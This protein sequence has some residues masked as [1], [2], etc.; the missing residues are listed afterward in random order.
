M[1]LIRLVLKCQCCMISH[2]NTH[3]KI[4]KKRYGFYLIKKLSSSLPLRPGRNYAVV[5]C[6]HSR[7]DLLVSFWTMCNSVRGPCDIESLKI[8]KAY[9]VWFSRYQSFQYEDCHGFR[10]GDSVH[11][12]VVGGVCHGCR[13]P[14]D[15]R[16]QGINSNDIDLVKPDKCSA[17]ISTFHE[18]QT[19]WQKS[20]YDIRIILK[21]K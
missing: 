3:N 16:S 15:V 14:G 21:I 18:A 12:F 10:A 1:S 4:W 5:L 2:H 11:K 7:V 9:D 13:F 19:Y 8:L 6:N 20:N 17:S